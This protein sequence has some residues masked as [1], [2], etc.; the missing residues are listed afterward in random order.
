MKPILWRRGRFGRYLRHLPR[1][2]NIRGTW[3]HRRLGDRLFAPELWHP[4]RQ[5]FAAGFAVGAF[6]ALMPAPFQML[7]AGLIAY[8]TRVNVP[9]A[10][11]ATWISN[12]LTFPFFVYVQYRIGCLILARSHAG[13]EAHDMMSVI[14]SA[15][16]PFFVGAFPA[17]AILAIIVYPLTLWAWDWFHARA[18]R[19]KNA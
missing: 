4:T 7:A 8:I 2:K 3:L 1:V 11:A 5:R 16:V 15:P 9:A 10:I 13:L 14:K 18:H 19:A 6:F 12:P 17:A